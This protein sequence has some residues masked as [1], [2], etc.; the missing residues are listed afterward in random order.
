M[1]NFRLRGVQYLACQVTGHAPF[2]SYSGKG[3]GTQAAGLPLTYLRTPSSRAA[4]CPGTVTLGRAWLSHIQ[5][6]TAM[7]DV[8]IMVSWCIPVIRGRCPSQGRRV[9]PKIAAR[10]GQN[11][12]IIDKNLKR[13]S[14][15]LIWKRGIRSLVGTINVNNNRSVTFRAAVICVQIAWMHII[16]SEE[17]LQPPIHARWILSTLM[18][19]FQ[20]QQSA[21]KI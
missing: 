15:I 17:Q 12:T 4:S 8:K 5:S 14:S 3:I 16:A 6:Q 7:H 10:A 1:Q 19:K 21:L 9:L 20:T 2:S 13:D 18:R 11:T